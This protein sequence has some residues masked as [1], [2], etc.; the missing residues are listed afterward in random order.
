MEAIFTFY[1]Q[2]QGDSVQNVLA[3]QTLDL[4]EY[5]TLYSPG[6][7]WILQCVAHKAPEKTLVEVLEKSNKH[8]NRYRKLNKNVKLI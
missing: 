3:A 1:E 7:D 8:C 4:S 5:L 2:I 6:L